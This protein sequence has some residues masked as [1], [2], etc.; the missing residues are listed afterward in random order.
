MAH[1]DFLHYKT[2][3]DSE[4]WQ[5][6]RSIE[7]SRP[8]V[9]FMTDGALGTDEMVYGAA[10]ATY[11]R[12]GGLALSYSPYYKGVT[13]GP[14]TFR[15]I[16]K[17]WTFDLSPSLIQTDKIVLSFEPTTL[18]YVQ[19]VSGTVLVS[20]MCEEIPRKQSN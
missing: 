3:D 11:L 8:N 5:T 19:R 10:L 16:E 15:G 9:E 6:M 17:L 14:D 12:S 2:N 18:R 4:A 13:T 20:G 1:M 7:A